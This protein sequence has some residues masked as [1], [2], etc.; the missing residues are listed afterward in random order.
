MRALN[1]GKNYKLTLGLFLLVMGIALNKWTLPFLL[2]KVMRATVSIHPANQ[3]M[4]F[5]FQ[6]YLIL[7]ALAILLKPCGIKNCLQNTILIFSSI[8]IALLP[9]EAYYQ[10]KSNS[11]MEIAN[12]SEFHH[13]YPPEASGYNYLQPGDNISKV[14]IKTNKIGMRG[15]M[16]ISLGNE[17]SYRILLLGDSFIQADELEYGQ[18]MAPVLQSLLAQPNMFVF[19]HGMASWAP[20]LELNWLYK[21]YEQV[22]PSLVIIVLC[23]NDFFNFETKYGDVY[24]TTQTIFDKEGFPKYF[25]VN[26]NKKGYEGSLFYRL[27]FPE[28]RE[29]IRNMANRIA[30]WR[31]APRNLGQADI[32]LLIK[33]PEENFEQLLRNKISDWKYA[34]YVREMVRL[35]RPYDKW[36][37]DTSR[38]VGLS[39]HY[40]TL[41]QQFLEKRNCRLVVTMAPFG[42]SVAADEN[43]KGK[44]AYYL[45]QD[46]YLPSTGIEAKIQDYCQ[47]RGL[48]YLDLPAILREYRQTYRNYLYFSVD[49]H[50]NANG[51]AVIAKAIHDFLIDNNVVRKNSALQ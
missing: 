51:H 20:L 2:S 13:N 32:D 10:Y 15:P 23:I 45:S 46:A 11:S 5:F 14:W 38:N 18:T 34:E 39:L 8:L 30:Q 19:E 44:V 25:K 42:W 16:P 33:A 27:S 31:T 3:S 7:L 12:S 36:G 4:I 40:I 9:L 43:I 48:I 21:N 6:S 17:E 50:W 49:G 26:P 47:R 41:M 28:S 29:F 35:G 37:G 24:Y 1:L 22:K